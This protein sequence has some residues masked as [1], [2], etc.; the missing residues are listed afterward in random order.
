ASCR[1][2][3]FGAKPCGGP[4]TYLIF[5][6]ERTDS[7]ELA[8]LVER[9]NAAERRLNELEGRMSDCSVPTRPTLDVRDGRCTAV[10][11]AGPGM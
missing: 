1:A 6:V 9:Y 8:S 4:W 5:S 2:I 11:A 3:P 7:A 10:D